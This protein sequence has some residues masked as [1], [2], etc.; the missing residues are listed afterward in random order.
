MKEKCYEYEE[1]KFTNPLL[2]VEATYIIHLKNNGRYD[3]IIEQIQKYNISKKVYIVINKGYKNCK[4]HE[5]ITIP[6]LDLVDTYLEIFEHA[7][8][9]ENIL[10][11]EDDFFFDEKIKE[12]FHQ[13]NINQF[14]NKKIKED[15]IYYLGTIPLLQVPY[16]YYHYYGL[17]CGSH[18]VIYSKKNR[19]KT[20]E[21][22][23]YQINDWDIFINFNNINRFIYYTPLCYQLFPDTDNSSYWGSH[24]IFLK[25]IAEFSKYIIIL[26]KLHENIDGYSIFYL[27]SKIWILIILLLIFTYSF[28]I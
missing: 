12:N 4:K 5:S 25:Y 26:L 10:I 9:K 16:N 8:N 23:K 27:F 3:S 21:T 22:I 17:T 13:T 20:I 14:I 2:N 11:L 1:Y 18:A 28:I 19:K 7:Q 6:P 15:F 24:N